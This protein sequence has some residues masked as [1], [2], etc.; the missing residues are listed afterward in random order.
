MRHRSAFL[1]TLLLSILAI[2]ACIF[3]PALAAD[4]PLSAE[5]ERAL[6]PKDSFRE[7]DVCPEMVVV[8]AGSFTMGSPDNEKG[9]VF[10]NASP[11]HRVTIARPFAVGKFEVTLDQFEAFVK[12]T[13]HGTGLICTTFEQGTYGRRPGRS[14]RNPGFGQNGS[15]PVT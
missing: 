11:Q 13:G 15:H 6:K 7:C 4:A 14:F 9:R 1:P 2:A 10:M 8:T 12:E 3:V 5:R